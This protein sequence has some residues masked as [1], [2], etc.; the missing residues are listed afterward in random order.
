MTFDEI[1]TGLSAEERVSDIHV[2]SLSDI[3]LDGSSAPTL[4]SRKGS[5][6]FTLL[7]GRPP[8]A[9]DEIVIG[10][11]TAKALRKGIR[12]HG[13]GR[14]RPRARAARGRHGLLPQ[15]PHFAFDQGGWMTV[16]GFDAIRPP[17]DEV[18]ETTV[19]VR[20]RAA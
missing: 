16:A 14:R 4:E 6:N 1:I 3:D 11:A 5:R 19:L 17:S 13:A 20:F 12:G 10:P 9:P 8:A 18:R 7:D 15:T 2:V